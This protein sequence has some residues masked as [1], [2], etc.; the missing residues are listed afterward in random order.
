MVIETLSDPVDFC[1]LT[2][3]TF[4]PIICKKPFLVFGSAGLYKGLEEMGFK[5]FPQLYDA[6]ILDD[7]AEFEELMWELRHEDNAKAAFYKIRFA[8]FLKIS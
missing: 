4:R 5:L 1:S 6:S 3:K 2:E 8:K 7:T